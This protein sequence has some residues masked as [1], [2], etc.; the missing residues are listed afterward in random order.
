MSVFDREKKVG[1]AEEADTAVE[2]G[3]TVK[4]TPALGELTSFRGVGTL[5]ARPKPAA[6]VSTALGSASVK[7]G[8][9]AKGK[10]GT[11]DFKKRLEGGA[12]TD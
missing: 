2:K 11:G 1:E 12:K 8:V 9:A 3:V 4:C 10:D 7:T 6:L 5:M